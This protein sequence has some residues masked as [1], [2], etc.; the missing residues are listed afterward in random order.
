MPPLLDKE[1]T[2]VVSKQVGWSYGQ[3]VS[4][5]VP[6]WSPLAGGRA[7]FVKSD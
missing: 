3:D 7:H 1:G 5:E 2:G 6:L 4:F